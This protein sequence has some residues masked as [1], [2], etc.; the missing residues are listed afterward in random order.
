MM[1]LSMLS[2][3]RSDFEKIRNG[4]KFDAY[5][6]HKVVYTLFPK[7]DESSRT[8]LFVDKGGDF[9]KRN[10]LIL[11]KNMPLQSEVGTLVSKEISPEYLQSDYY[12]FEVQMNPVRRDSKTKKIIPI[13]GS[14]KPELLKWFSQKV[15]S[16]GFKVM[17]ESLSVSDT[18]V[19]TFTKDGKNVVLSKAVF[20]GRLQ[21]IDRNL[22]VKSFQ[23]GLGRGKAFGFGLLQIIPISN[24]TN[25]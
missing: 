17:D 5:T 20:T 2:L 18:Q 22:F 23:E 19:V 16:F 12:G 4:K 8:F 1:Y 10:I 9:N 25:I 6:L 7:E 14:E 11:S 21:V 24:Q 13:R 15:E 3:S